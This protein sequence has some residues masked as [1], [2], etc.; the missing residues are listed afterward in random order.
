[1]GVINTGLT[2]KQTACE[3]KPNVIAR[4]DAEGYLLTGTCTDITDNSNRAA[5]TAFVQ[6]I[7]SGLGGNKG[8]VT[9]SRVNITAVSSSVAVPTEISGI[10]DFDKSMLLVY[11]DGLLL[12]EGLNYEL[13]V[14]GASMSIE[15]IDYTAAISD[16]ISFVYYALPDGLPRARFEVT[17]DGIDTFAI[18]TAITDIKD[19][20]NSKLVVYHNGLMIEEGFEYT[21]IDNGD[22]SKSIKLLGY[23]A[24]D[25]DTLSCTYLG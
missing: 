11:Q 12:E 21:I 16:T 23:A 3:P 6:S 18:P 19:F 8:S 7:V 14:N 13:V 2:R 4:Y 22:G 5:S 24:E 25:E 20:R 9:R 17:E 15:F 10:A 1:M